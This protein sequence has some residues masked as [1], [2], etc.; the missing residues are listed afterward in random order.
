MRTPRY[1]IA[2]VKRHFS[3][4]RFRNLPRIELLRFALSRCRFSLAANHSS[5][6]SQLRSTWLL[7]GHQKWM[8]KRLPLVL[9]CY[10][11]T[12]R[13]S[14]ARV[15]GWVGI[16]QHHLSRTLL[17]LLLV[18]TFRASYPLLF[19][20]LLSVETAGTVCVVFSTGVSA[21]AVMC[22]LFAS[23]MELQ[24]AAVLNDLVIWSLWPSAVTR[25]WTLDLLLGIWFFCEGGQVRSVLL[26][27]EKLKVCLIRYWTESN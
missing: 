8:R 26:F 12:I 16:M 3:F 24:R 1:T 4:Y 14:D 7:D 9:R 22:N 23:I 15:H 20:P 2:Q 13:L 17:W 21:S 11:G 18:S 27:V 6:L 25:T 19:I 10:S 5:R